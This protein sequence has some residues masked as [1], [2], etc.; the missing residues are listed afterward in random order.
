VSERRA[1]FRDLALRLAREQGGLAVLP[2]IEKE[3]LHYGILAAMDRARYLDRLTFQG[4]TCLR[5]CYGAER[6]SEDLDFCAGPD[7]VPAG[8]DGLAELVGSALARRYGVD[9]EVDAPR[10]PVAGAAP[11]EVETWRVKVVTAPGRRDLPEQRISIQIANVPAHTR[12]VRPLRVNYPGLPG[13]YA[14]VLV[15]CESLPELCADK[16]KAFVTS[17]FV[18]YRD[19]WDLR[20]IS[21]QS[22]FDPAGLE[23][24]LRLKISD[25]G[26]E[27]EFED[28]LGRVAALPQIVED[29]A[30]LAQLARFLPAQTV[31]RTIAR[32]VFRAHLAEQVALLYQQAGVPTD[33]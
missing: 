18:R 19:L 14:D 24:L 11:V 21:V 26:A 1:G 30:F 33:P 23:P 22:G 17:R 5:L 13:S 20:W 2:V 15:A 12:A 9:V 16:L 8:F 10:P 4:G 25:Y 7:W 31:E 6:Y 28:N 27:S 3:I 29:R 32:P